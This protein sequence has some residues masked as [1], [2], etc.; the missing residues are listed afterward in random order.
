LINVAPTPNAV[1]AKP[2]PK[3]IFIFSDGE[4]LE[5]DH[6]ILYSKFLHVTAGGQE[7]SIPLSALDIKKTV[8]ANHERGINIRIP[9]GGNE[10]FL[11][12]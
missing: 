3:T 7:R 2:I 11:A 6:Y 12:F 5:A 10:L 8:A 9:A 4:Q 1:L